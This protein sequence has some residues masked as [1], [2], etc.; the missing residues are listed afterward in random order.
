MSQREQGSGLPLA[1]RA[2]IVFD[3]SPRVGTS[4]NTLWLDRRSEQ[5]KMST[6]FV[7]RGVHVLID[8]P[9]GITNAPLVRRA[10]VLIACHGGQPVKPF[11][12]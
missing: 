11:W 4:E 12:A 10:F 1:I 7:S 5:E 8:G 2:G 9:T 3:A 6:Y